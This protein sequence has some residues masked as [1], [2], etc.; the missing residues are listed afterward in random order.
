VAVL[1]GLR[2]AEGDGATGDGLADG[3]ALGIS[4]NSLR[5]PRS[6]VVRLGDA[7]VAIG[8]AAATVRVSV[9]GPRFIAAA[10]API[11]RPAMAIAA[12]TGINVR[13]DRRITAAS[14][15]ADKRPTLRR[16][17]GRG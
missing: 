15:L 11:S 7:L 4:R 17:Q 3:E 9:L 13:D 6:S 5:E 8:A 1:A 16:Q 14:C 2:V 12:M 10:A